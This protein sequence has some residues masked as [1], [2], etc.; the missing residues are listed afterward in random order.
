MNIIPVT[1]TGERAKLVPISLDHVQGLYECS[2]DPEIWRYI[3]DTMNSVN[4]M[5]SKVE[6]ALEAQEA[7]SELVFTVIDQETGKIAGCTRYYDISLSHKSLEIGYTWLTPSVWRTRMNTECKYLLLKNAFESVG[8]I[9]VALRTDARNQ[10][11][12]NA[13]ER[14]GAKYEGTLRHHRIMPDGYLRDTVYYSILDDEWP[15]VKERLESFL[16]QGKL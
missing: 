3:P 13:I 5:R 7:G 16:T 2:T 8:A 15:G 10:R 4:D 9:R 12:R 14:L 6:K 11:S 1:L